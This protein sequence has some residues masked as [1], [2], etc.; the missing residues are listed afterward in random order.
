MVKGTKIIPL[1]ERFLKFVWGN[2]EMRRSCEYKNDCF[3]LIDIS[4]NTLTFTAY[5]MVCLTDL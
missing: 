5:M 4:I 2:E 1:R 3:I